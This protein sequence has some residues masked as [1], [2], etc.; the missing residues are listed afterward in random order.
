M[1]PTL[2]LKKLLTAAVAATTLTL[3]AAQA[4]PVFVATTAIVE[5]PALDAVRDGIKQTLEENGFSGD[6]LKFTYE[7]AQGNPAMAAQI[8]R[9]LVGEAPDVI[10]GISTPSA[11]S[12]VSATRDIPVV[13]SAVTDP[14]SAKLVSNYEAPG[15]NVTGLSDMTPVTQHLGLIREF[16]PNLKTL[17]V[18][19]NPGEPNA[20]AIVALLKEEAAKIGIEI[21]EAPAPKSSDVM[22]ATQK[23][24]G[25]VDAIYCPTDN[26]ILTALESV[27]K[28]GI[29]AKIP[30][31][32]GDTG[33]VERG[34]VAALGFNYHDIGRQTGAVVVRILKGEKAGDIPVRVAVGSDLYVNTTMAGRMGV[35]IPQSVLKRTTKVIQ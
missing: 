5:H 4:A 33:S 16:L 9:K 3:S 12:L 34:A 13:F 21:V 2:N 10:V 26:T 17:G 15:K 8:A 1:K 30:V 7:S 6:D 27:V 20:V 29:D 23:L 11:Q 35:E 28:V 24:I 18:P 14:L 32:S 31:F 25:A 22:M 19:Y